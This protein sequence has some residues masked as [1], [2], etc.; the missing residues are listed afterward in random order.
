[1]ANGG[2]VHAVRPDEIDAGIWNGQLLAALR[3]PL[4]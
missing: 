2:E 4:A 1:L 3:R